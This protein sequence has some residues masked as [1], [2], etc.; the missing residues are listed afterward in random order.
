MAGKKKTAYVCSQ[1]GHSEPKWL[2]RCPSCG[3]WNT[4][5]EIKISGSGSAEKPYTSGSSEPVVLS[6]IQA[7][8]PEYSP[9]GNTEL[10]RVL[11]GGITPGAAILL[12]GEPGIG[13]S[14]LMLQVAASIPGS[15]LYVSGEETPSQIKNRADRL[16]LPQDSLK[17]LS[18][19]NLDVLLEILNKEKPDFVVIDS[20]QTFISS[21]A[22]LV[23]GTANQLKTAGYKLTSWSKASGSPV[24]LIAHVTKEGTIAGPKVIEHLVDTV[25]YFD[26]G[27]SELRILRAAK[28]RMGSIDEIGLFRMDKS[29]LSAIKNPAGYFLEHRGEGP[30]PGSAVTAVYE[31]SRILLVEIQALTVPAKASG[32]RVYSEGIDTSRVSRIAAVLEK[33]ASL[34]L[35]DNDI[36][37]NVAGGL[38]VSDPGAD[39]AI[40]IAIFSSKSLKALPQGM[41]F[42]GE[43]TLAGE[44]RSVQHL[45]RRIKTAV[46]T[47]WDKWI[48]SAK[49]KDTDTLPGSGENAGNIREAIAGIISGVNNS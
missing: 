47:G 29:G 16:D 15:G 7:Q 37:I 33:H 19:N 49:N 20:I 28:N 11:G 9:T 13:K 45:R 36:Y 1:C 17:V 32:G 18:E 30:P 25:L 39:L 8:P 35:S 14:T 26:H 42:C 40:A 46:D 44:I 24:I 21:E 38:K 31:G 34:K 22:G 2:G 4:F 10:D 3:E 41:I 12:G 6:G 23:P 43:V 48:I 5:S 27:S